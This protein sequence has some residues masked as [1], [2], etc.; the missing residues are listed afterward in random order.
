[1]IPQLEMLL[2][3]LL[4]DHQMALGRLG[5]EQ[6]HACQTVQVLLL[7]VEQTFH[8]MTAQDE[9]RQRADPVYMK[10]H[11]VHRVL[12]LASINFQKGRNTRTDPRI[13]CSCART[14][15]RRTPRIKM[16]HLT[17]VSTEPTKFVKCPSVSV[18]TRANRMTENGVQ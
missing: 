11:F 3:C 4:L 1:V 7:S 15:V 16:Q 9:I 8:M 12:T 18:A 10:Q 2:L 5:A 6:D 13:S 14:H 17:K